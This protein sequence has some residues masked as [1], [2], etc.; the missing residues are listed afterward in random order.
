MSFSTYV[1]EIDGVTVI[2]FVGRIVLGP[3]VRE[4]RSVI[5]EAL[6]A[7][8]RKIVV[9][10]ALVEYIDSSGLGELVSAYTSVRNLGGD[11]KLTSLQKKTWDLMQITKLYTVFSIFPDERA[12][13]QSFAQAT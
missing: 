7:G 2:D 13:L 11:I 10:M 4:V 9:N 8:Q 3:G 6:T 1:R 12:A 5:T